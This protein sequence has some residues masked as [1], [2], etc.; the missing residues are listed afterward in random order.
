M[1]RRSDLDCPD[2]GRSNFTV[3]WD[4]QDPDPHRFDADHDGIGCE[5]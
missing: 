2:V 4:V 1:S 5:R 3:R